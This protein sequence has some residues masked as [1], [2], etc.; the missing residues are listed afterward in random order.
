M[1]NPITSTTILSKI[2]TNDCATIGYRLT[3]QQQLKPLLTLIH[4]LAS[5]GTR[6]SEFVEYTQLKKDWDLLQ[7]DLRGHGESMYRGHYS[8]SDW[9]NDINLV[10]Q[11][12]HYQ[13]SVFMGHSLGAQVAITYAA[14]YP[15]RSRGLILI[16]PVFPENLHG[17]L[18]NAK[19]YR[20]LLRIFSFILR[21]LNFIGVKRW[22]LP[23]RN[24]RA[25]DEKTRATLK[26]HPELK[27]ADLY[28]NPF[29]DFKYIPL[30]NYLQD[31]NEVIRVLPALEYIHIPVLVLLSGGASISS[32]DQTKEI[33]MRFPNAKIEVV[34]ADHWLLTEKPQE[35]RLIIEKWLAEMFN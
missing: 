28:T 2:K 7:I 23:K 33:I 22:R 20:Y 21:R 12:E 25:L 35:T 1:S 30:A 17:R 14:Q 26:K 5:N 24:L 13:Q 15:E 3:R 6:F 31:I 4:G 9:L 8:R 19:S 18:S 11:V 27:I 29:A 32:F 10:M 34:D 16:D